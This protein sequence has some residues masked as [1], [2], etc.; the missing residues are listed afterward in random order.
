MLLRLELGYFATHKRFLQTNGKN[1]RRETLGEAQASENIVAGE[2]IDSRSSM[3][4]LSK[5][6][7]PFPAKARTIRQ[8]ISRPP[9]L[10][11]PGVWIRDQDNNHSPQVL[12]SEA[13]V[14]PY[15]LDSC[16]GSSSGESRRSWGP[17]MILES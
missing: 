6:L 12:G 11:S 17:L 8:Q 14:H 13:S 15:L 4:E 1:D 3:V 16:R 5:Y 2:N 7:K 10:D 9:V